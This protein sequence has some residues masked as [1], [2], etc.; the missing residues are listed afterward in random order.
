M[1]KLLVPCLFVTFAVAS[2]AY[3]QCA[4]PIPKPFLNY[5]GATEGNPGYLDAG[6]FV[7][8]NVQYDNS[9]FAASPELPA[10]GL[11]K[12]ASRTYVE[13]YTDTGAF[14]YGYCALSKSTQLQKLTFP[15]KKS[16]MMPKGFFIRMRDR[17]CNKL[18]QS[19][20]HIF[21]P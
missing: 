21:N 14:I 16:N 12:S 7:G 10:C 8:N 15:L 9:L 3:A 19:N 17:K 18:V 2:T 6:F 5:L 11:N 13:V 4:T 20:T 1:R